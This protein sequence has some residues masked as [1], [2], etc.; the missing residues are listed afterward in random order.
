MLLCV[1]VPGVFS[2][3]LSDTPLEIWARHPRSFVSGS[4]HHAASCDL[5]SL[6]CVLGCPSVRR[7]T[8]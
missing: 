8:V 3:P 7:S 1:I 2:S 4:G 6:V 5:A